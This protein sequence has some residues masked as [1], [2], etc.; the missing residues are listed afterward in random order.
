MSKNQHDLSIDEGIAIIGIGCNFPKAPNKAQYWENLINKVDCI[1]DVPEGRW[2]IN[3][4]YDPDRTVP[5]KTYQKIGGFVDIIDSKSITMKY[6]IPPKTVDAMDKTQKYA[7]IATS[8]AF[9]DS[10]Y[11]TKEFD[12]ERTAVIIGNS[13]GGDQVD[14]T[15]FRAFYGDVED[16]LIKCDSFSNVNSD[17]QNKIINEF[18]ES[19]MGSLPPINEDSMPGELSNVIAGRIANVFNLRGPSFSVDAACASS[20]ASLSE[21]VKGLRMKEFDMV[22]TGGSDFMM[23]PGPYI[24]FSKIGALSPDGSRPFDANAN[25]FVMGEGVGIY[26]LKRVSDARRDGDKIYAVIRSIGASSDG[27]GKG[28]TAPNPKGQM[29]AINRAFQ[30]AGYSPN[31]IQV[32]EAHGTATT[33]GD[34]AEV[35]SL[36]NVWDQGKNVKNNSISIGS[37]KSMIGHLKSAAGAAS[38]IKIAL[39]LNE[40]TIAPSIN[41]E[42]PNPNI[43]FGNIPFKV[44]TD[45]E[46]WPEGIDGNPRRANVSSFGFGGTNFHVTM[47]E[48]TGNNGMPVTERKYYTSGFEGNAADAMNISAASAQQTTNE[49]KKNQPTA[50]I[51]TERYALSEPERLKLAGEV[52]IIGGPSWDDVK[53]RMDE[54]RKLINSKKINGNNAYNIT[55]KDISSSMNTKSNGKDYRLGISSL[56]VDDFLEKLDTAEKSLYDHKKRMILK[57]KGIFFGE[58][59]ISKNTNPPKIAF[60]FPGQG[61]QYINMLKDLYHKYSIVRETY[62]EADEIMQGIIGKKLTEII[63]LRD[64]ASDEEKKDAENQLKQ[65]EV[66][67]PSVLTANVA[68]HRLLMSFGLKPDIVAGHSLGEYGALVASGVLSFKDSLVAVSARGKE[69]ANVDF[70]DVGKMA[71]ISTDYAKVEEILKEIDGY[72]IIANKNCYSQTVVAGSSEAIL[73]LID[74]CSNRGIT[75]QEIKVSHAFHSKIVAP[76]CAPY[77]RVLEN[78][79]IKSPN[80]DILANLNGDYYPKGDDAPAKIVEIL[81]KHIANP[82]E[83]IKQIERMYNDGVRVFIEIGPKRTLTSFTMNII[84]KKEHIAIATNHPKRG[85]IG[86]LNDSLA[87]I[88]TYGIDID[89]E[90]NGS[91]EADLKKIDAGTSSAQDIEK[92]LAEKE[93]IKDGSSA[94]TIN[95]ISGKSGSL[96]AGNFSADT[97]LNIIMK[98]YQN[99]QEEIFKEALENYSQ[100]N[101]MLMADQ[102]SKVTDIHREIEKYNF[103]LEKIMISGISVGLPGLHNNVF[104]DDAFDRIL[105]GENMIDSLSK[106]EIGTIVN[107]NITRLVKSQDG[108]GEFKAIDSADK[109]VKL[110][111]LMGR[112]DFEEEFGINKDFSASLDISSKLGISAGIE[113]LRDAGIP[114]VRLYKDTS[115]G[116]VLP[117]DWGLP[118]PMEDETGI[119]FASAFP[120]IDSIVNEVTRYIS[121]KYA[122]KSKQ[123]LTDLYTSVIQKIEDKNI[124]EELSDWY[125]RNYSSIMNDIGEENLYQFNRKFLFK[126]HTM[127]HSQLAQFIRAKGPNL[128]INTACSSTV[129][130]ISVAEDWIRTGRAKRVIVVGGDAASSGSQLEW[131]LSGFLSLGALTTEGEYK[132]AAL[133]FDKRRNGMIVGMGAVGIILEAES[134]VKKRGMD[135]IAELVATEC[136]NSAYHITRLNPSHISSV[137]ERLM[138]KVEKK[139]GM[140]REEIANKLL[141]M[142]HET[143]TPAR[144]GSS[145]AEAESLRTTFGDRYKDIIVSNTKGFT[146]HAM[147]AGIEDA[148]VVKAI[149]T[150]KIPPIANYKEHDPDLGEL[151]LSKGDVYKNID[152]GLRLAAGFGSQI[153]MSF[154]K[155]V[156]RDEERII[157]RDVYNN[158]LCDMSGV[159][160]AELEVVNRTLRIKDDGSVIKKRKQEREEKKEQ[161]A[162]E[163]DVI[164]AVIEKKIDAPAQV[165]IPAAAPAK[166]EAHIVSAPQKDI[167]KNKMLEIVAEKTGYPEDLIEFDLDMES[168]L[169]IDT[170]KQAEVFGLIREAFDIPQ[171]EGIKIKDFPTL[172]HVVQFVKDKAPNIIA[173]EPTVTA[174][175][176]KEEAHVASAPQDDVIKN[177]MLEIVAEKTGY[178]EDL[179]EFDLD[180]ESDLGID[181]VKQAEVFGLIRE[182]FDIPQEE[183]IK[184]KDFPTLNH[185][186]QFV[187]DKAPNIIA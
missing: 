108:G 18:R 29:L 69:I 36:C 118:E 100:K 145:S 157:E 178:P 12:R 14:F 133:P 90:M 123:D 71:S 173:D 62:D 94:S 2:D 143:Y 42:N 127:G 161:T 169:G 89:W 112:F 88:S 9:E 32:I 152:Y 58:E 37:V 20:M 51:D 79:D 182:A 68:M 15:N 75:A 136:R 10:G 148:V 166:E 85:G 96:G 38:I 181:T 78:L 80:I 129:S 135:P 105:S 55:L 172:N 149:Q 16:F 44:I 110:A 93:A 64:N 114:L 124:R 87:A 144:G 23:S 168:D 180:M 54:L 109:S 28:I 117:L 119:I 147:G 73:K 128:H 137:M 21:S 122:S 162:P 8:D 6:K 66:T 140:H 132:N 27:K 34:V 130:G 43:D 7:V 174:A 76:A 131:I 159:E 72:A 142:S 111:G 171:E 163:T 120:G 57:N 186:V 56:S 113:A 74:L 101:S 59:L 1:T 11:D 177:K 25:G 4:H 153:G 86:T 95:S 47:E 33:V 98:E 115:T 5:D 158:W 24:K 17:L 39:G 70:G 164:D 154:I 167:I 45:A 175:P 116:G 185:V 35:E 121:S 99:K 60:L 104:S 102:L 176:A 146:G 125:A 134:E 30:N 139:T 81:E 52:V 179:I 183:G 67:Q 184:I 77:R 156:S 107:K 141:F 170:V 165:D 106:D 92:K 19:V 40:K 50:S 84:G 49:M 3:I 155:I 46:E 97:S 48:D 187:K 53:N 138:T 150:Q 63:F 103:N 82:V 126:I 83:F 13:M 65:T 91:R 26:I 151:N 41:Y 22:I 61:A 160:N 31:T